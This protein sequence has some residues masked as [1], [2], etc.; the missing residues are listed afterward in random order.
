M[1]Y[2][3]PAFLITYGKPRLTETFSSVCSRSYDS[4]NLITYGKP[5][6]T[7]THCNHQIQARCTILNNL[8]KAEADWDTPSWWCVIVPIVLNNLWKAEADWDLSLLQSIL[9]IF[10]L[11]NLW[12]AEA[13][14]DRTVHQSD[15]CSSL[16]TYGMPRLTDIFFIKTMSSRIF[17]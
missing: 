6:L 8:W 3:S 12:K 15:S 10:S 11:N 7:E 5:R 17:A 13:D 2:I 16:I 14:W 1:T 4:S 9:M